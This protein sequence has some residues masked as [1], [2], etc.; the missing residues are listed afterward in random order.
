MKKTLLLFSLFLLSIGAR[1]QYQIG[2]SL[3]NYSG[4]NNLYF[5]AS[6]VVDSRY[7]FYLT[8][9]QTSLH[10]S[11]DY[12]TYNGGYH[13][14]GALVKDVPVLNKVWKVPGQYIDANGYVTFDDSWLTE[15]LNGKPKNGYVQFE[16]RLFSFQ[17]N[18]GRTTSIG[19]NN[20]VRGIMQFTNVSENLARM[21]RYGFDTAS[22]PFQNGELRADQVYTDNSFNINLFAF[23]ETGLTVGQV[24]LDRE[25]NF[26]K[27]GV[28]GKY[29]IPLYGMYIRNDAIDVEVFGQDSFAFS[30]ADIEYGYIS[31]KAFTD[32][33]GLSNLL[34]LGRGFG[35]D[36]GFTYEYRPEYKKYRYMMDGKQRVDGTKNK[37]LLRVQAAL[38]DLGTIKV[39]DP[40]YVRGYKLAQSA[41]IQIDGAILDTMKVLQ[42]RYADQY[43]QLAIV[44]SLVGRTAG[45]EE[46]SNEFNWKLPT[47]LNINV[48]YNIYK[49]FYLN[50]LWIQ[51]LRG[52]QVN[53]IAGFSLL[54][55]TPRYEAKWFEASVPLQ[56]TRNYSKLR[57]G[58]YMRGGPFWIGTDDLGSLFAKKGI[59]GSDFYF[60]LSLPLY[61]K[62]PRDRDK[63]GVSDRKDICRNVPGVWEF[64]GCPDTDGDSIPDSQDSCVDIPGVRELHGC[65]DA[66]GDGI[67]DALDSCPNIAGLAKF[68]GCPDSDGDGLIDM[69]DSCPEIP[70][71]IEQNGCPD[72]DGDGVFDDQDTCVDIPGLAEFNGCPDRDRDTIPDYQDRCPDVPGLRALM[73]CPDADG[74][75]VYDAID[76]CPLQPGPKENN[77]CPKTE[78]SVEL[79]DIPVED[80]DILNEA[81]DALEFDLGSSVISAKSYESLD[82]L[83]E[84][85]KKRPEYRIYISGHTDN[86]GNE[87]K[88]QKLSEDRAKAIRIYLQNKGIS[89]GRIKTEGFGSSRPVADNKT[90]E[91][92][93]KNRRVEFRVIK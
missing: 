64:R 43:G 34:K 59:T 77:G 48:D 90:P 56:L 26:L 51:S 47:N 35:M 32:G 76:L 87:K 54:S 30:N 82:Q 74:D 44:D 80:Q 2:Q 86:T 40:N 22:A 69:K 61:K 81:F 66:D 85:L 29:F 92:R 6:N 21:M 58:M 93:Q 78:E 63:D 38:N 20:R 52:K 70:G 31:E 15:E 11:N 49:G 71:P 50:A 72:R 75:G 16:Q 84:L 39:N 4:T 1:S 7:R 55:F 24:L 65:P 37:Y 3:S 89:P 53:G 12:I 67:T 83:A 8:F 79:I 10:F 13:P 91:G 62:K 57:V 19:V 33:G 17:F 68:N 88:N 9:T 5:N 28:T 73:G 45:F 25:E 41:N 18:V 46:V 27:M 36:I 42:D 60:G 14:F 23:S